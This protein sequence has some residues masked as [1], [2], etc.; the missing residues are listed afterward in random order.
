[1][2]IPRKPEFSQ[3]CVWPGT[4]VGADQVEVFEKFIAENFN[5]TRVQYLEEVKTF[6]DVQPNGRLVEGTGDRNDVF[7]AV[8]SEDVGK[9]AVPRLS[10]G[11]RWIEDVL[12]NEARRGEF[13][14]YPDR[15]TEYRT[16]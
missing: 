6:P 16:W 7:F 12:D 11:I 9:F 13:R 14:I 10:Y 15:V 5:N 3:V 4:L 1:M 2:N 8:H